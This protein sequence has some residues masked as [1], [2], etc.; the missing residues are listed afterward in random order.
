MPQNNETVEVVDWATNMQTWNGV[1]VQVTAS[2]VDPFLQSG[3]TSQQRVNFER[4]MAEMSARESISLKKKSKSIDDTLNEI[5]DSN[6]ETFKKIK[7]GFDTLNNF[8]N[9]RIKELAIKYDTLMFHLVGKNYTLEG[10]D[11]VSTDKNIRHLTECINSTLMRN[12]DNDKHLGYFKESLRYTLSQRVLFDNKRVNEI[13]L[14]SI[15]LYDYIIEFLRIKE[16][17]DKL[18]GKCTKVNTVCED[19]LST[20]S[21]RS[22]DIDTG[23]RFTPR[24]IIVSGFDDD[25]I[26]EL[27]SPF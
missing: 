19:Y 21:H 13:D 5:A 27:N 16:E 20:D 14:M 25:I 4:L 17:N 26:E 1:P 18:T 24:P 22:R 15:D 2:P 7:D 12:L 10:K 23:L 9:K 6:D 3:V 8:R 11:Q